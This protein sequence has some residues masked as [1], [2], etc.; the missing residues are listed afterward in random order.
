MTELFLPKIKALGHEVTLFAPFSF[1]GAP[2]DWGGIPVFGA[3][4]DQAGND[5]LAATYGYTKADV[6]IT[7]CDVFALLPSRMDLARLNVAHWMPVDCNPMGEA[8]VT[9]LREGG[10]IPV[11]MSRFGEQVIRAEGADPLYVPHGVDTALFSPGDG[12]AYRESAEIGPD[13]FVVG[14]LGMNRDTKRKAFFEQ[15]R[16]FTAFHARHPDSVLTL[17][18]ASTSTPGLNLAGMAARLGITDAVRFPDD[19]SYAMA[20]I[21]R[22]QQVAWYRG[23]DVL[24]NCSYGEGFGI[25]ALE[26]QAC[27]VPV[28]LTNGHTGPELC[29]A[30]WLV[31]GSPDWAP[32]HGAEWV[33]PDITDIEA[34]Y[35]AAWQARERGKMPTGPAREFAL[36]YDADRVVKEHWVPALDAIAER[37]G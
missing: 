30:G 15:M 23:L 32:G 16:A 10:G 25:A 9:V 6:L 1:G 27:G 12:G 13:T 7:L 19:Y 11:A 3:V 5:V 37:I 14:I 17:H 8:D 18:A 26:A 2:L 36:Q 35:E 21:T 22:E 20:L 4:K 24:S 28:I 29:G 31:S 33:R 34:A